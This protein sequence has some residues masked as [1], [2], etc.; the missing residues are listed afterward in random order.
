[1]QLQA[2]WPLP[3][4]GCHR[5]LLDGGRVTLDIWLGDI[6]ELTDKLDDSLNQQVDAWF[7]DGF[8]PSK[9][10]DM[11]S[12]QLFAAMARLARPGA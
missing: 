9:N 7:L 10:P 6:N 12:P 1:E 11:W 5:L 4:A 2:Q 3:I 8:A